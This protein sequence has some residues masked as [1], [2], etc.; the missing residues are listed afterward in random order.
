MTKEASKTVNFVFWAFQ[1]IGH[2]PFWWEGA[3]SWI[4]W[5]ITQLNVSRWFPLQEMLFRI[6]VQKR[7]G[8]QTGSDKVIPIFCVAD[9]SDVIVSNSNQA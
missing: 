4:R 3:W 2:C 9:T 5:Y 7:A 6:I 1:T 8:Y